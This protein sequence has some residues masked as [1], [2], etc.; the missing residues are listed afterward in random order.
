MKSILERIVSVMFNTRDA[1]E[2][3]VISEVIMKKSLNGIQLITRLAVIIL[4]VYSLVYYTAPTILMALLVY[5]ILEQ[6][7]RINLLEAELKDRE[8]KL[9]RFEMK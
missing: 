4:F 1:Q 7:T 8:T 2:T 3:A 6:D 9:S 5:C